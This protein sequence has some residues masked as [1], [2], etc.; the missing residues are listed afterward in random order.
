VAHAAE[1]AGRLGVLK[2]AA[3]TLFANNWRLDRWLEKD[4]AKSG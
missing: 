3:D 1:V 4:R 2:D